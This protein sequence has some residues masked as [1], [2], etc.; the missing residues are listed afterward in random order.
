MVSKRHPVNSLAKGLL[1]VALLLAVGSCDG[2]EASMPVVPDESLSIGSIADGSDDLTLP[3]DALLVRSASD[4]KVIQ[5]AWEVVIGRCMQR[6]GLEYDPYPPGN[7]TSPLDPTIRYGLISVDDAKQFGYHNPDAV[8]DAA[9]ETA[10][11]KL[12]AEREARGVEYL[13][14]LYGTED[15]AADGTFATTGGCMDEANTAIW[16]ATGGLPSLPGYR[17]VIDL[18]TTSNDALYA[19]DAGRRAVADWSDCMADAGLEYSAWWEPRQQYP[20]AGADT[21]APS[22]QE[23]TTAT[24]DARCRTQTRLEFRLAS[25]EREILNRLMKP[26]VELYDSLQAQIGAVVSRASDIVAGS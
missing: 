15:S 16:G 1:A 22:P 13:N 17:R 18:Q 6:Q 24:A 26:D 25:G 3:I 12:E 11:L 23:L 5:A 19:E 7:P 14:A 21:G 20:V 2:S 4:S 8:A 9:Q 10:V